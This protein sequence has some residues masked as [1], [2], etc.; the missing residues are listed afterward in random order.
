MPRIRELRATVAHD[1]EREIREGFSERHVELW[2]RNMDELETFAEG[3]GDAIR[4]HVYRGLDER[5]SWK[6]QE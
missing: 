6:L 5:L 2:Q 4:R 1:L 3:R